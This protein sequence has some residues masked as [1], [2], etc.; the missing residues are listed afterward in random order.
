[1]AEELQSTEG[2]EA[3]RAAAAVPDPGEGEPPPA[4]A[5]PELAGQP[6]A[7]M[8]VETAPA[9]TDAVPTETAKAGP[10]P[11]ALL[12]E[13]SATV[14]EVAE[15]SERYHS[16]AEHRE[17]VIDFLR[18]ELDALRQGE[19]RG[20]LRPVLAELCRLRDDLLGQADTLPGNF[21][22]AKAAGL[23][24][25]YAETLKL[26]LESNGVVTYAPDSGDLFDP[27]RH[28]RA[29]GEPTADPALAGHVARVRRD[30]YLDIEANSPIA[31]AEV[32]VFTAMKTDR[33]PVGEPS[34]NGAAGAATQATEGE[35]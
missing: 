19:R 14:R 24:R 6:A 11:E 26:T 28:R 34:P 32:T 17:G 3:L 27:R 4:E 30:G 16:R 22:A 9:E 8:A 10:S 31:P 13:I 25:S 20:V 33:P 1:M 7:T 15:L 12:A 21:D 5:V 35:Q 18:S 29:G 2:I 23:L